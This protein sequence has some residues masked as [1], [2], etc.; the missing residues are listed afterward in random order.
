MAQDQQI[1]YI[2]HGRLPN[3]MFVNI[4]STKDAAEVFGDLVDPWWNDSPLVTNAG[5]ELIKC[6]RLYQK[7]S[8][9]LTKEQV[10]DC[11]KYQIINQS[12]GKNTQYTETSPNR[13]KDYDKSSLKIKTVLKEI[14]DVIEENKELKEDIKELKKKWNRHSATI[15]LT[16]EVFN[17][18]E[19]DILQAVITLI[20]MT[21]YKE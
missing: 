6:A 5:T 3:V 9:A 12:K 14:K 2:D 4:K 17:G 15:I 7:Y 18:K 20:S 19:S 16:I 21:K 13:G 11:I 10:E 8:G 1:Q